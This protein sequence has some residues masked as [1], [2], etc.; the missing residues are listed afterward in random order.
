MPGIPDRKLNAASE[1][2]G[3][4]KSLFWYGS[5]AVVR[6][7]CDGIDPSYYLGRRAARDLQNRLS[8]TK[9]G[10]DRAQTM[11]LCVRTRGS[12]KDA[13]VPR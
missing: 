1:E 6:K 11:L 10:D 9:S 4:R 8:V 5:E 7:W 3:T 12:P 2:A 13:A